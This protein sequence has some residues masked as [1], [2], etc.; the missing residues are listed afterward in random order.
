[1]PERPAE[2]VS[3]VRGSIEADDHVQMIVQ[4]RHLGRDQRDGNRGVARGVAA[5]RPDR[6]VGPVSPPA[7][8]DHEQFRGSRRF[9][10]AGPGP[11]LEHDAGVD[12]PRRVALQECMLLPGRLAPIG[13]VAGVGRALLTHHRTGHERGHGLDVAEVVW[14]GRAPIAARTAEPLEPSTPT[15]TKRLDESVTIPP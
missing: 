8:S 7:S 15:T 6:Q 9:D 3:G 13:L 1:M 4:R 11:S 2:R 5:H 10:Q 12:E 14:R